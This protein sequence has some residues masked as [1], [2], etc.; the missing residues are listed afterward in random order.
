MSLTA[1]GKKLLCS[2]VVQ[3]RIHLNCQMAAEQVG[4]SLTAASNIFI[5]S[6]CVCV[7]MAKCL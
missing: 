7:I 3:Y 1:G 2:L 5:L 4:Y 6:V